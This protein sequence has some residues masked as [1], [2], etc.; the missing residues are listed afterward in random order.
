MVDAGQ[1]WTSS[2][3]IV[4]CEL[5]VQVFTRNTK[6]ILTTTVFILEK[7]FVLKKAVTRL[8]QNAQHTIVDAAIRDSNTPHGRKTELWFPE[9]KF[10][11]ISTL[12]SALC[13]LIKQCIFCLTSFLRGKCCLTRSP[14]C[15]CVIVS[16]L[17]L[18]LSK[19]KTVDRFSR[20]WYG[21]YSTARHIVTC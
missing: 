5:R 16:A 15:M 13:Q 21:R 19:I 10:N 6:G 8:V 1:R 18:S 17:S 4:T 9:I 7:H 11:S 14:C 20:T 12:Y 3:K 2:Y